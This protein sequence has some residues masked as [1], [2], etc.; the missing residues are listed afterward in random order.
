MSN[1]SVFNFESQEIR[2][3]GTTDSPW[4]VAVDICKI[5]DFINPSET[6]KRLDPDE[7]TLISIEGIGRGK[8]VNCVNESGLY[9]LV[10]T[11]RKSS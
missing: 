1:L 6:L 9:S 10:L 4:W 8:A 7:I 5:L 3:V 11:S 2:F